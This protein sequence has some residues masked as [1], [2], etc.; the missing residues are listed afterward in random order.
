MHQRIREGRS[1]NR[2]TEAA[3]RKSKRMDE[4][5]EFQNWALNFA[6]HRCMTDSVASKRLDKAGG[7]RGERKVNGCDLQGKKPELFLYA[8]VNIRVV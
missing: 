5:V 2:G 6:K 1:S 8:E 3:R 7:P 4:T